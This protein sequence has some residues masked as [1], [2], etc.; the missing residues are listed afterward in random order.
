VLLGNVTGADYRGF[1][2]AF[3]LNRSPS[4]P[5]KPI[6]ILPAN[7]SADTLA[8]STGKKYGRSDSCCLLGI[9]ARVQGVVHF[10]LLSSSAWGYRARWRRPE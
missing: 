3:L 6:G 9:V 7:G 10:F 8:G 5:Y 4:C 1:Q 2:Q